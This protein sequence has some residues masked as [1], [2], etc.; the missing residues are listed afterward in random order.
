MIER[1]AQE[2]R[3]VEYE[4]VIPSYP[5]P[6]GTRSRGVH[7]RAHMMVFGDAS[8]KSIIETNPDLVYTDNALYAAQ[9]T[10]LSLKS[11]KNIPQ[12]IHLRGDWWREYQAWVL[13]ASWRRRLLGSQ[14]YFYNW[15]ALIH[16][17]KVTPI[18]RWLDMI[19]KQHL[20]GKKTE[21]VYQGVDP[22]QF[23]PEKG[24]DFDKPSVAI[25][26][27]HTILPKVAGLLNFRKVVKNMPNVNFYIA[28]GEAVDQRYLKMVR[29]AYSH[30]PNARFVSGV[31]GLPMVR[32]MLTACDCYVLASELDCCPTT[33]L[34]ASLMEKPV[35]A[36][37][38]GGVP[39]IILEG[40]TG[41][42]IDNGEIEEWIRKITLAVTDEKLSHR[43]GNQGR[44]WVSENFGWKRV[45][46]QVENLVLAEAS[47]K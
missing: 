34:E 23:Y 40:K 11:G 22:D 17:R 26:Q 39:E 9:L 32:K 8:L 1:M 27:N 21:V 30:I 3:S 44:K 10:L 18:C 16:A 31:T 7:E 4:I 41:W 14:Q 47:L 6:T 24:L 37:R 5:S 19:V 43:L 13:T 28:E 33:V 15:L 25:I 46:G 38:I 45:A 20:P 29:D 36:S 12:I 35:I 2:F 42:T